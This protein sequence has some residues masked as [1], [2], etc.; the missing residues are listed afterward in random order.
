MVVPV[1]EAAFKPIESEASQLSVEDILELS[2]IWISWNTQGSLGISSLK[3]QCEILER[4]GLG[5]ETHVADAMCYIPPRPTMDNAREEAEQVMLG[6]LE[7]LFSNTSVKPK[8]IG[9]LVVDCS[10]FSLITSLSAMIINKY[11]PRGKMREEEE[12]GFAA[13]SASGFE[14]GRR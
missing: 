12:I 6:T 2:H 8:D 10:L 9:I 3:F 1:K 11:K 5:E 7:N 4:S 13:T 14:R